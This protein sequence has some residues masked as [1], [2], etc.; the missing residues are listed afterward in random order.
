MAVVYRDQ[1]RLRRLRRLRSTLPSPG[2]GEIG[3]DVVVD[4]EKRKDGGYG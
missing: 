4:Y 3:R 1:S 2:K